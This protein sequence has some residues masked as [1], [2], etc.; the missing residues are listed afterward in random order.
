MV[1]GVRYESGSEPEYTNFSDTF[2]VIVVPNTGE[3]DNI[4]SIFQTFLT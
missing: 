2:E 4:S 1:T 3:S